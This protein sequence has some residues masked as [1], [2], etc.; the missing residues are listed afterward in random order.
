MPR[1]KRRQEDMFE[2]IADLAINVGRLRYIVQNS[3][4][5]VSNNELLEWSEDVNKVIN[6]LSMLR[7]DIIRFYQD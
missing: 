2:D 7:E 6:K 1:E 4:M 3:E 5:K